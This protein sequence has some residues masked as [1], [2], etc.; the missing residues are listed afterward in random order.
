MRNRRPT[1][2][3]LGFAGSAVVH[4]CALAALFA[5]GRADRRDGRA[6]P[7][8]SPDTI[9]MV[10]VDPA[11]ASADLLATAIPVD[12]TAPAPAWDADEG[13][14]DSLV[15]LT[16]APSDS[17]GRHRV[18]PAPDHGAGGGRPPDHAYRRDDS[19][20]RS[21]LTDGAA[22]AQPARL[23]TSGR[24]ASPQ[25]IRREPVVG[26]GDS[27]RTVMPRRTPL[28]AANSTIALGGPDGA[29]PAS[30]AAEALAASAAPPPIPSAEL[31]ALAVPSR[32]TGPL[33]AEFGARSFDSERPGKAADNDTLRAA[34]NEQ[35]PGLTDFTRPAVPSAAAASDG[36]GPAPHAGAVAR[37]TSGTA[38]SELGVPHREA[39]A[40]EADERARARRYQRYEL[41][42][43]Q[44]VNRMLEFPRPLA[45]R[46][47][48]GVTV[49]YFV[50]G[51]DGRIADG[52]RVV[53]SSGF[54]E[55]DSAAVRAV[56]RG[57]PFPPMPFMLPMSMSVIFDNP[58]IR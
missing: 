40:A 4:V 3:L 6:P 22:E 56:R 8:A 52:P 21:R 36:R 23:R 47:E 58:V 14:R 53:K 16:A 42:I 27:V 31:A 51:P 38:P 7:E 17:D 57:A 24:P 28:P 33:D 29:G 15:P 50:V 44:R 26:I 1:S 45:V 46:L 39:T 9:A 12:V 34:S 41:E 20:L 32:T 48:Q 25:A 13:D 30:A 55:F 37:P 2:W 54:D 35:H 11:F 5:F 10:P 19:T 49:V 18:A 43:R